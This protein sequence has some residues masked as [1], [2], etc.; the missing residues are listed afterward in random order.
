MCTQY[1][2][3]NQEA[4]EKMEKANADAESAIP[5][6]IARI[7]AETDNVPKKRIRSVNSMQL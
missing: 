2:E 4:V 7:Q 1:G 6:V 5:A 3:H